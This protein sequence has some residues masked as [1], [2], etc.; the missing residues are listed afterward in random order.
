MIRLYVIQA[1]FGDCFLL[2][3][4]EDKPEYLLIDGGPSKN[5]QNNLKPALQHL[6]NSAQS[7]EAIIVSHVDN[8]HI[9]GILDLLVD[10]KFQVDAGTKPYLKIGQL[11]FNSF[12]DTIDTGDF[13][14]RI[15]EINTIAGV[16]GIRMQEMSIAFNGI[17]EGY[18]VLSMARFL[19]IPI[20]PE[21]EKGF[22]HG[23]QTEPTFKKSNLEITIIG[24]T[25]KNLQ[26][27]Q[28]KWED[29]I[30]DNEQKI[31]EGK[32]T[33]EF[34]AMSDRSI[35]NLSSIIMLIKADG[36]T[37]LLTGDCRGDHLQEGLKE[38]GLSDTGSFH[39]D[40]FKVPHHGSQR[41][42]TKALFQEVTADM[43]VISADGTNGNP[44][45]VT[46]CWIVEAAKEAGRQI[47]IIVTNKTPSTES[48]VDKYT[49][50]DWG[51]EMHYIP[52]D[53]NFYLI[54]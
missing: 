21:T 13:E 7:L 22:Y 26:K 40:I 11:W 35:P 28:K 38:T 27:L 6:L 14:K 44:D 36:K 32:Y 48:L 23:G 10:L 34:A 18:Q 43:Y 33:K 4:G 31:L 37:I 29:W 46:L 19:E 47:Q 1:G 3:Y 41:N 50:A 45:F 9:V 54:N 30:R 52:T 16:N 42:V 20:N 51:Y 24:P 25:L 53:A 49:P 39:V 17:K 15:K 12:K 5:Y 8:D 2:E